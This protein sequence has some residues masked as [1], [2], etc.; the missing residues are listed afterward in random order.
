MFK[1]KINNFQFLI[2]NKKNL[3]IFKNNYSLKIIIKVKKKMVKINLEDIKLKH[4]I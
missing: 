3:E 1:I 2:R 4:K